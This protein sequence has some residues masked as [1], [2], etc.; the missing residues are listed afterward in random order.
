MGVGRGVRPSWDWR[1]FAAAST[2][3]LALGGAA[4]VGLQNRADE[5]RRVDVRLADLLAAVNR[6]DALEW[7][8]IARAQV[9]DE[10][11]AS[12]SDNRTRAEGILSALARVD[13][14]SSGHVRA[15]YLEYRGNVDRE[16]ERIEQ[17]RIE[18][19]RELDETI[20]DPAY[21]LVL[22]T[23]SVTRDRILAE[24]ERSARR[25]RFGALLALLAASTTIGILAW[26]AQAARR[27]EM[28]VRREQELLRVSQLQLER[29]NAELLET[30]RLKGEFLAN[31]SHELRTPL[32]GLLGFIEIMADGLCSSPAEQRDLLARARTCGRNLL[33]LINDLLDLSR[34]EA[35]RMSIRLARVDVRRAF[36]E[37]RVL[38]SAEAEARGL[39]LSFE[40]PDGSLAARAD[41]HRVRQVLTH[42]IGNSL[43]FTPQ[44]VITVRATPGPEAGQLLIEVIDTGIGI[45]RDRQR[46]VFDA[47][48]QVD[49]ST[50]RRYGGIGIGLAFV[51]AFVEMMGGLI[52]V[53]SEGEGRG[54]RMCVLLPR[55]DEAAP[56]AD[57]E[58][59]VTS[60]P[61]TE[62][63]RIAA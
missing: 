39:R 26:R 17:G 42:L 49:G 32:A 9:D 46:A 24:A 44:G 40:A 27:N 51:R 12:L 19:A 61:E 33:R 60:G 3:M 21:E 47:F 36:E 54:T 22:Q 11:R 31:V 8:A 58:A 18:E 62:T 34:L 57:H 29:A 37:Q 63:E 23:I 10:L 30:A 48:T 1:P 50:T 38:F 5:S 4:F 53:E 14:S 45:T 56:A 52:S 41:E 13:R 2:L 25:S 59:G 7:R 20:V 16:F 6:L 43:K 55:W 28:L 35:G 15:H